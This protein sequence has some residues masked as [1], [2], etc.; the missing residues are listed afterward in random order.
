MSYKPSKIKGHSIIKNLIF[1]LQKLYLILQY[2][3]TVRV[4]YQHQQT[5]PDTSN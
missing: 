5:V 3:E 1:L 2:Y 4:T